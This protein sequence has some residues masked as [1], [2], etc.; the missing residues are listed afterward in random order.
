MIPYYFVEFVE[1]NNVSQYFSLEIRWNKKK[2]DELSILMAWGRSTT[3]VQIPDFHLAT[4]E[5]ALRPRRW[6]GSRVGRV[7]LLK[8]LEY[9]CDLGRLLFHLLFH[10]HQ[11]LF[12]LVDRFRLAFVVVAVPSNIVNDNI[13]RNFSRN[14]TGRITPNSHGETGDGW[15]I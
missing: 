1:Q 8:Q 12:H 5:G 7:C 10:R 14:C 15:S 6:F 13:K 2:T 3:A 4:S 11:T 9:L